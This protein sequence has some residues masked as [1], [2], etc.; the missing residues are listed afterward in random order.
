MREFEKLT[1]ENSLLTHRLEA[2]K[3]IIV[4]IG[5]I[6]SNYQTKISPYTKFLL[7]TFI[8][9]TVEVVE[10]KLNEIEKRFSE[11]QNSVKDKIEEYKSAFENVE[12]FEKDTFVWINKSKDE[13][14]KEFQQEFKDVCQDFTKEG[15]IDLE[16]V[17][18]AELFIVSVEEIA[19]KLCILG[20]IN[21]C[22]KQCKT[23][24]LEINKKLG[25]WEAK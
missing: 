13:I 16:N 10:P 21:E 24:A 1:D 5:K 9:K 23:K 6:L 18:D 17:P 3:A 7:S 4:N 2:D 22:I 11:F 12:A 19:D 14:S 8:E 25:E 20:G 15:K